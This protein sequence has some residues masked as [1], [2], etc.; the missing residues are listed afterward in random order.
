MSKLFSQIV[1]ILT[2]CVLTEGWKTHTNEYHI[3]KGDEYQRTA[4]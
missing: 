4:V 2:P 1:N 3:H